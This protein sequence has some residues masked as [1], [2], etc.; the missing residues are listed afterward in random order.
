MT[1][2]LSPSRWSAVRYPVRPGVRPVRRSASA[3]PRSPQ[4]TVSPAGPGGGRLGDRIADGQLR[5]NSG[6]R[7]RASARGRI[8]RRTAPLIRWPLYRSSTAFPL[9]IIGTGATPGGRGP[10]CENTQGPVPAPGP[11]TGGSLPSSAE[12]SGAA[13]QLRRPCRNCKTGSHIR[14]RWRAHENGVSV[15]MHPVV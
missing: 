14:E 9:G 5:W 11:R 3:H 10:A 1:S 13:S 7:C 4:T 2:G 12:S 6:W 8:E 15:H